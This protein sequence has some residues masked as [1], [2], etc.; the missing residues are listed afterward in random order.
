MPTTTLLE[1][2]LD[3]SVF[4]RRHKLLLVG[5]LVLIYAFSVFPHLGGPF[6]YDDGEARFS[7][8]VREMRAKNDWLLPSFHGLPISKPPLAFWF[9]RLSTLA[10]GEKEYAFRLPSALFGLG[11]ILLTFSWGSQAFSPRTGLLAGLLLATS[12]QYFWLSRKAQ[13]DMPYAF[14]I[15]LA[16]IAFSLAVQ[17]GHPR[18]LLAAGASMA[19]ATMTKGLGGVLLPMAVIGLFVFFKKAWHLLARWEALMAF[20]LFALLTIP[21]YALLG[22][23]FVASFFLRDHLERFLTGV[24]VVRPFYWYLGLFPIVF[25]PWS[26]CL[27]LAFSFLREKKVREELSFPLIWFVAWFLLISAS[28]GKQQHYLLPLLPPL[29]LIT[30]RAIEQTL[31]ADPPSRGLQVSL[32]A[33]A[34]GVALAALGYGIFL[35]RQGALDVRAFVAFAFLVGMSGA[36]LFFLRR[37]GPGRSLFGVLGL[38]VLTFFILAVFGLPPLE[39]AKSVEPIVQEIRLIVGGH[40]LVAYGKAYIPTP[41]VTYYLNLPE[42]IIRFTSEEA[43]ERFLALRQDEYLITT[44]GVFEG[45]GEGNRSRLGR[46]AGRIKHPYHRYVLFAP[47][48]DSTTP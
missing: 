37:T 3:Q 10:F 17:K 5:T 15:T 33:V 13:L 23:S 18:L 2:I 8:A 47:D 12:F 11:G 39:R 29:A 24:D 20:L 14:F 28:A 31:S 45:L 6:I 27:P 46:L 22:R 43:L 34:A 41:R 26:L 38:S 19:L 4:S 9:M 30:A 7:V 48:T 16:L 40:P 25:F 36:V 21:Y 35:E 44:P 42:P 1:G 32:S